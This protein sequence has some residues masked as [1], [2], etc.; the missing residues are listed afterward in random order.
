MPG[1]A[2]A[3]QRELRAEFIRGHLELLA[4]CHNAGIL[5]R[6]FT[7]ANLLY[8][9]CGTQME[10]MWIDVASCRQ[11]P[12]F[13]IDHAAKQDIE[14]LFSYFDLTEQEKNN[15]IDFYRQSR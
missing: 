12:K 13:I 3:D 2:K 7:P 15:F 5:H 9:T 11:R 14:Q 8:K 10:F 1:N 6:G 4:R